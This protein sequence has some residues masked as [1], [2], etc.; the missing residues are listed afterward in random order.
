LTFRNKFDIK[1]MDLFINHMML[2]GQKGVFMSKGKQRNAYRRLI[3]LMIFVL[4]LG[5]LAV[6]GKIY[7]QKRM[8]AAAEQNA[9]EVE[10]INAERT[11]AY[12]A[13]VAKLQAASSVKTTVEWPKAAESGWDVVDLTEFPVAATKSVSVT[14]KEML[15]GGL[16]VINRWHSMPSDLTDDMM[17]SIGNY[18]R[19]DDD[20]N[21]NVA[22]EDSSVL[23]QES[24]TKALMNLYAGG[25]A[26]GLE[27]KYLIVQY[28]YRSMET[29][30]N[31]WN[32]KIAALEN[33]YS[34]DALIEQARKDV[35]Y[36]GTSDYQSGLSV[37]FYNYKSGDKEFNST[38]LHETEHGK[39]LYE[40]S[41][42]YGFVFRFPVQGFPYANT[43]DKSY[44]TGITMQ[45]KVYRYVGVANAAAMTKLG[46]CLEEYV[47]YLMQHP[48]IAVYEDGK[49]MYEIYRVNGGYADT[50]VQIPNGAVS[51]EVSSDNL[52]GLVVSIAY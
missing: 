29:Q 42:K 31:Y 5:G 21:N 6:A 30:T 40:N 11:A 23:L 7:F 12:N 8:D 41:W 47:E 14:R 52:G 22:T 18:S 44:K 15:A 38:L 37:Y 33:K 1:K 19:A 13:E 26:A 48:H 24:A 36:P 25:R 35:S 9:K 17:V 51:Y 49:L 50:T 3:T 43:V 34:G 2:I 20:A 32:K 10:Q 45:M 39:W 4:L 46:M 28:G 27:M 16:L